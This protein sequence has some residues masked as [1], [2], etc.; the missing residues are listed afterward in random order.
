M[1]GQDSTDLVLA[2]GTVILAIATIVLAW[3]TYRLFKST[4]S[5]SK[6]EEELKHRS[7]IFTALEA[8]MTVQRID[9]ITFYV[10]LADQ[11]KFPEDSIRALEKLN[12]LRK[13]IDEPDCELAILHLC[14]ILDSVR[15]D[16]SN[17][18]INTA[19]IVAV[20]GKIQTR[21]QW[22]VNRWREQLRN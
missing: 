9:P 4:E 7:D 12:S 20:I 16:K 17:K 13:L 21:I 3:A 10:L 15:R 5:L 11:S 6:R 22:A 14:N 18:G 19:E 8:A 2:I 1:I